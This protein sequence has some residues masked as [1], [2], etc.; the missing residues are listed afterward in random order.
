M[1]HTDPQMEN[2]CLNIGH[3]QSSGAF[4]TLQYK[5][6]TYN[7]PVDE[8]VIAARKSVS[9]A[10]KST[11]ASTL[12]PPADFQNHVRAISMLSRIYVLYLAPDRNLRRITSEEAYVILHKQQ[13]EALI[14]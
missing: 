7:G 9:F 10:G 14:Q 8:S 3:S 11:W 6:L 12:P 5:N 13:C 1:H 2:F 4:A